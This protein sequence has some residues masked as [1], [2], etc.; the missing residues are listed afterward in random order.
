MSAS[1]T[2]LD[3][4]VMDNMATDGF[5]VMSLFGITLASISYMAKQFEIKMNWSSMKYR[6]DVA[7]YSWLLSNMENQMKDGI[8]D[9]ENKITQ[10]IVMNPVVKSLDDATNKMNSALSKVSKD[11]VGLKNKID[12]TNKNKDAKNA[13]L[14]ITLQNNILALKEG[15]KKVIASLIIQRHV[16]NGTIKMMSGT[17]TLQESV[18]AAVNKVSGQSPTAATPVTAPT[19]LVKAPTTTAPITATALSK[20]PTT[21]APITATALSKEPTTTA[22]ITTTA[23]TAPITATSVTAPITATAV[24]APTATALSKAATAPI[25]ATAT[26]AV[27]AL[28]KAVT[29]VTAP[30]TTTAATALSKAPT[31]T[32]ATASPIQSSVSTQSSGSIPISSAPTSGFLPS[33]AP[34]SAFVPSS[35]SLGPVGTT[36]TQK[37]TS[38][39]TGPVSVPAPAPAPAPVAPPKKKK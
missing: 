26:T 36:S 3:L 34:T 13:T 38:G 15:M 9:A 28:P 4:N 16:N 8:M 18:R 37:V 20:E 35:F 14:V 39:S 24:T 25:T 11:V 31:T 17:R 30:I 27:T 22:P 29:A 21:T 23:V 7:K 32:A 19:A 1:I 10:Q 6:P 5:Y 12:E 2:D 33:S